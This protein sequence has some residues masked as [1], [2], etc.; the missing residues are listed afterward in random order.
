MNMKILIAF[1]AFTVSAFSLKA[2]INNS[3][4]GIVVSLGA[5]VNYYYGPGD[6][7]FGKFE[8]DRINGQLN[9]MLGLTIVRDKND[10][11][12]VLGGFGSF[13]IN[14]A[15]TMTRIFDD[16]N[17]I[18][19][20]T[21]QNSSNNFYQLEGGI[22]ISETFRISTGVGRQI[23]DKQVI[24]SSGVVDLEAT[25]LKYNSTTVGFNFN[26][27]AVAFILN[28]NFNYGLDYNK[29]VLNPSAGLMLRL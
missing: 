29:T 14:N 26:V 23:F 16:Q 7:N 9:G 8:N 24:S 10:R 25:S 1:L 28:C 11:R 17:Y 27:G 3:R 19:L 12:T 22:L 5:A 20:S 4:S 6:R 21:D 2:Q 15:K 18:T 13:G